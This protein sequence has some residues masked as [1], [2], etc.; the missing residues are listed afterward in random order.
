M[1]KA[2]RIRASLDV[3][4]YFI[5]EYRTFI[6]EEYGDIGQIP[7][8][9]RIIKDCSRADAD[10]IRKMVDRRLEDYYLIDKQCEVSKY[11]KNGMTAWFD[12]N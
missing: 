4:N 11:D 6:E 12:V 8:G 1:T 10:A 9:T 7:K 5:E 3:I 2:E